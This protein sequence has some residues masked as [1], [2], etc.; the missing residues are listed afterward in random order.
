MAKEFVHKTVFRCQSSLG[1]YEWAVMSFALKN[2]CATYQRTINA[3]FH[4]LK[5]QI[6]EVY[7]EDILVKSRS[8]DRHLEDLAQSFKRMRHH[9]L[10]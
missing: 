8:K 5:R 7:I 10:K 4:D 2:A 6:V 3:I 1:T 9:G